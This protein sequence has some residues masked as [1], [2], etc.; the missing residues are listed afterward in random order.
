MHV[1]LWLIRP[2][3]KLRGIICHACLNFQSC[4]SPNGSRLLCETPTI[5]LP[6]D[7]LKANAGINS[8]NRLRR[9]AVFPDPWQQV[10][11]RYLN[12]KSETGADSE[13]RALSEN[14][15]S[16][17]DITPFYR[18]AKTRSGVQARKVK[19]QAEGTVNLVDVSYVHFYIGF[20]LDGFTEYE[21]LRNSS[22]RNLKEKSE[23]FL[24]YTPTVTTSGMTFTFVK[25]QPIIIE[26][27]V[28]ATDRSLLS[29]ISHATTYPSVREICHFRTQLS[30]YIAPH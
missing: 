21:D 23:L 20:I 15:G 13:T 2:Y 18:F 4:R 17:A 19:R 10:P 12:M 3:L 25:G 22:Q 24:A 1:S 30:C 29:Q 9:R 7:I 8:C 27:R 14:A 11:N 6:D 26:V 5:E 16:K 28:H